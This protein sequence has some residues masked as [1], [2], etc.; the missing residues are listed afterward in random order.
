ML[1]AGGGVIASD[2]SVELTDLVEKGHIPITTTLMGLGGISANSPYFL[3]MM[4][5]HGTKYANLAVTECDLL[6]A[7]G[8]RFDDR[9]TGR[10]DK[11]A[12]GATYIHIDI[13]PTTIN[14]N[15]RIQVPIV[16]DTKTIL[17]SLI[18]ETDPVNQ[19]Q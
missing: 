3:G 19:S 18:M 11:F 10:L 9:V 2:A 16:E 17:A 7:V 15:I 13:D 1:Y 4:G 5:M 6:I 14:K 12:P 8:A